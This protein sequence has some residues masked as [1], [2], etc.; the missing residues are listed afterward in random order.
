MNE[1]KQK[2]N[3][4]KLVIMYNTIKKKKQKKIHY[5][6]IILNFFLQFLSYNKYNLNAFL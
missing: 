5:C 4:T 2:D 6:G 1:R 3:R